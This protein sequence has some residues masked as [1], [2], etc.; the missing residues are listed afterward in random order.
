M[1]YK[2]QQKIQFWSFCLQNIILNPIF[3][4][5]IRFFLIII[6]DM[7]Q[8]FLS[9]NGIQV[10]CTPYLFINYCDIIYLINHIVLM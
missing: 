4:F 2:Q 6:C 5:F 3:N 10:N 7:Y 1:F 9:K 8:Q